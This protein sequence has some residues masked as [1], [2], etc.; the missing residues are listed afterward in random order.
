MKP[1][2]AGK[3]NEDAGVH[4][5]R[6][7]DWMDTHVFQE[8]VKVQRFCLSLVEAALWCE[9]LRPIVVDWNDLQ[10]QF[11]Q[12]YSR[13][14]STRQQLFHALRSFHF[15]ENS[16]TIDSYITC[17]TQVVLPLGYGE[18][19]ILEVSKNTL[20]S[21]LY[22]VLFPIEDLRKAKEMAKRTLIKKLDRQLVDQSSSTPFISIQKVIA[23][24]II[25]SHL[26]HKIG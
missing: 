25:Q 5:L 1:E 20:L 2:F 4:L 22:W 3:P 19:Q 16:E 14:G 9:S 6:T 26:I 15:G 12:Q 10:A 18:P 24:I 11:R 7:N 8:G 21:R 13:K 23:A 17:F